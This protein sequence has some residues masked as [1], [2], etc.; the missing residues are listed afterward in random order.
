M[1]RRH[2]RESAPV[3]VRYLFSR[4]CPSHDAGRRLIDTAAEAAGVAVTIDALEV[5]TDEEAEA[6]SFPGSP[7][8]LVDGEDIADPDP[9]VPHRV[10]VCRAYELSDGRIGP[11]PDL[12]QLAD[13]LRAAAARRSPTER[14]TT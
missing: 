9:L 11:L 5:R 8:Y 14:V 4:E 3:E 12:S 1:P 7:T 13:A 2:A 6:M 10:G